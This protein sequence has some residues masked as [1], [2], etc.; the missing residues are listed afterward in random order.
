MGN[1]LTV[2]LPRSYPGDYVRFAPVH[3]H[4][5]TN[6]LIIVDCFHCADASRALRLAADM[7]ITM[8]LNAKDEGREKEPAIDVR[9]QNLN[10]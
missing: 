7:L 9:F 6:R 5:V 8:M 3:V 1:E 2:R 10:T 4:L